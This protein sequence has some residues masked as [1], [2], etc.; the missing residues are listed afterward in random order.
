[1]HPS[2]LKSFLSFLLHFRFFL[3]SFFVSSYLLLL[4]FPPSFFQFQILQ[5]IFFSVFIS[6]FP[7]FFL[8]LFSPYSWPPTFSL[9]AMFWVWKSKKRRRI[10]KLVFGSYYPL[11]LKLKFDSCLFFCLVNPFCLVGF[12]HIWRVY[13]WWPQA[14]GTGHLGRSLWRMAGWGC[15]S[16]TERQPFS[17]VASA[18]LSFTALCPVLSLGSSKGFLSLL[19]AGSTQHNAEEA[20]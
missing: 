12:H 7:H 11:I 5:L 9:W 4:R 17:R 3:H 16:K 15:C 14:L 19:R 8:P 20:H 10:E 18:E 13:V 6:S 2:S 1:M